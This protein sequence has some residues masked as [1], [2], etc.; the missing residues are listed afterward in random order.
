[1]TRPQSFIALAT[2]ICKRSYYRDP[3]AMRQAQLA[4]LV[5][6]PWIVYFTTAVKGVE[7]RVHPS[8]PR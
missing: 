1:M 5:K 7:L 8:L 6:D 3:E 4:E 2:A